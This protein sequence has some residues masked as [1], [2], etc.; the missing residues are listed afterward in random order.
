[1]TGLAS[2]PVR[3]VAP[4]K[5]LVTRA[6]VRDQ[7]CLNVADNHEDNLIDR[8]IATATA[9]IDGLDGIMGRALIDQTWT[10][11]FS[12]FPSG[13]QIELALCPVRSIVAIRYYAPDGSLKTVSE[14]IYTEMHMADRCLIRLNEGQSWPT[15]SRQD[16]AISIEYVAGY[17]P[18]PSDV[19]ETIIHAA[20]LLIA[21]YYEEREEIVYNRFGR[22]QKEGIHALLAPYRRH[23]WPRAA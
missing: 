7:A 12:R 19:P 14:D 10:D 4:K 22:R 16:D 8:L 17:G 2:R 21:T 1:M 6:Q 11:Y 23:V 18:D 9:R 15:T 3:T 20:L 13:R 5:A